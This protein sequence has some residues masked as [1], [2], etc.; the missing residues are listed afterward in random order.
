MFDSAWGACYALRNLRC[1]SGAPYHVAEAC[2]RTLGYYALA[3]YAQGE[4][5]AAGPGQVNTDI[6]YLVTHASL[7]AQAVLVVLMFLGRVG[8]ITVAT[9]LALRSRR[10]PYRYPE[11]RPIVG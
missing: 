5:P 2:L 8:T 10:R 9:G 3:L 4:G 7:T 1:P 6:I 11:E